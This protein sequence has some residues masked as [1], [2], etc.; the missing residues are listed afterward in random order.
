MSRERDRELLVAFVTWQRAPAPYED[1][2]SLATIDAFLASR[3]PAPQATKQHTL[4]VEAWHRAQDDAAHMAEQAITLEAR[5][6]RVREVLAAFDGVDPT[7]M[8]HGA[9]YWMMRLRA[10]LADKAGPAKETP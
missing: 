10:A 2:L 9:N 7:H 5:L 1:P 6:A 8:Q 4:L 3:E